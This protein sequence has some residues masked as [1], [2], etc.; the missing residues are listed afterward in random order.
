MRHGGVQNR[1][2]TE[3][4]GEVASSAAGKIRLI[5]FIFNDDQTYVLE[6]GNLYMRVIKDGVVLGAPYEIVTPYTTAQLPDLNYAQ[7]GD[8]VTI[9][10][11]SHAPRELSRTGDTSWTLSAITFAPDLGTPQNVAAS[12][13]AGSLNFTYHVTAFQI[14]TGEESLAGTDTASNVTDPGTN[15]H[16]ITWDAVSGADYY[17]VYREENGLASYIGET[18]ELTFTNY[19]IEP[20]ISDQPS[21]ARNPFDSAGNYPSAVAYYQQRIVYA[22]TTNN[23]ETVWTSRVGLPHNFTISTP[24]ENTD[25]VTFRLY[26]TQVNAVKHMLELNFLV[27]FTTGAEWSIRGNTQGILTPTDINPKPHSYNGSGQVAPVIAND[28][29]LY[30]QGRGNIVRDLSYS[31][32]DEYTG[33]DLTLRS[34]HLFE[35]FTLSEWAYQQIPHSIL[36]AIR[37]DGAL[38]ALT[39]VR[40]EQVAGWH[41]HD[42]EGEFE[43]VCVVPEGDEDFLYVTV[44]RTIDGSTVRY[45]ER[46]ATRVIDE[47]DLD[48]MIF[49]DSAETYDGWNASSTT[50][51]LTG[52]GWTP[53][54]LIT[55]TASAGAFASGDVGANEIHLL[56]DAGET[57]RM[58]IAEFTSPT[59]VKGYPQNKNVPTDLQASAT[60][61]WAKAIK[62]VTGMGHL[63]GEAVS[64]MGDAFVV[65]SP[66][67]SNYDVVSCVSGTVTL[68]KAYAKIHIG[69]PYI[70][71]M[72]TLDIDTING[73]TLMDKAINIGQITAFFKQTWGGF[74]GAK[75]PTGTDAKEDLYE[76]KLRN[77]EGYDETTDLLTGKKSTQIKGY[78]NN[79]GR[80][81]IRQLEPAPISVLS[82]SLSG[83]IPYKG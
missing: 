19:G 58:S 77:D 22:N 63:E 35:G 24:S 57:L 37:S 76:M 45:I 31:F 65:A 53:T 72:G 13:T 75:F 11:P 34:P 16:T 59:V 70:C 67:N 44:K 80:G 20:D 68:D 25:A 49:M 4:V 3:Y 79:N 51:T 33:V 10:H 64:V 15:D 36:W 8:I 32:V 43:N 50:I 73:E 21:A 61:S 41:R 66:N 81:V 26:G 2:G 62:A 7:S 1:P 42:T 71:D 5:P 48:E 14:S 69:L 82:L 56:D 17:R 78:W 39:Y 38:V 46:M 29:V 40:G 54:D 30:L 55:M 52:S 28:T 12:G 74:L 47:A 83:Y 60:T 9:V 27:I 18:A 6:F 23:P